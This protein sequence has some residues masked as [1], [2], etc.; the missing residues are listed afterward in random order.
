M[1]KYQMVFLIL[2]LFFVL[3]GSCPVFAEGPDVESYSF[4]STSEK[5][6]GEE[7]LN[8]YEKGST[9]IKAE[10]VFNDMGGLN[11]VSMEAVTNLESYG[12]DEEGN[13]LP[14][15]LEYLSSSTESGKTKVIFQ[16]G[17]ELNDDCIPWVV[18]T[19]LAITAIA[20]GGEQYP[21]AAAP[22]YPVLVDFEAP[23]IIGLAIFNE[24]GS[25]YNY[26][27]EIQVQVMV[28]EAVYI[29]DFPFDNYTFS[30]CDNF[31]AP[32]HPSKVTG[33]GTDTLTISYRL[34][35]ETEAGGAVYLTV[36]DPP[37][38]YDACGNEIYFSTVGSESIWDG[39]NHYYRSF[40]GEIY[41]NSK[42]PYFGSINYDNDFPY[43]RN[44]FM[45]QQET[46][47]EVMD[48][49]FDPAPAVGYYWSTDSSYDTYDEAKEK[50]PASEQMSYSIYTRPDPYNRP[51]FLKIYFFLGN[52]LDNEEGIFYLHLRVIDNCGNVSYLTDEETI[53]NELPYPGIEPIKLDL[54]KPVITC[55]PP[56]LVTEDMEISVQ[57]TD[58]GAGL[59]DE[60]QKVQLFLVGGSEPLGEISLAPGKG[61]KEFAGTIRLSDFQLANLAD[62]EYYFKILARDCSSI[63]VMSEEII[64]DT[65]GN[66]ASLDTAVFRVDS[67]PPEAP[68]VEYR[69]DADLG[70]S[71]VL[72]FGEP[73]YLAYAYS[74][75]EN[76]ETGYSGWRE[77]GDGN[78]LLKVE[79]GYPAQIPVE[80]GLNPGYN[81]LFLKFR[82]A[83]GNETIYRTAEQILI[84]D[85][86][87]G[88]A[89]F[90]KSFI[91]TIN[92]G[93]ALTME[94]D[95]RISQA[96]ETL[97][98]YYR[99]K[100]GG[101]D[102]SEWAP[103]SS[104]C[105]VVL[106]G[107]E[108]KQT[109]TVQ[110]KLV[111]KAKTY[112]SDTVTADITYDITGP[113]GTVSYSTTEETYQPVTATVINISDN[114]SDGT[115]IICTPESHTFIADTA[116]PYEFTLQD[117]AG[118]TTTLTAEVSWI[119]N[120][121]PEGK[122]VYSTKS[123]TN[124][125]V[126]ATL[127]FED[128]VDLSKITVTSND[129]S[130]SHIFT[131]NGSW[132]F[133]YQYEYEE[134][135]FKTG[136]AEANI[137]NIDRTGPV[138]TSVLLPQ[139][140][141]GKK[142]NTDVVVHLTSD[143]DALL[144]V[145]DE[146]GNLLTSGDVKKD[147]EGLS[148]SF[149]QN[150]TILVTAADI[151]GNL[152]ESK[153]IT[154]DCID[155]TPPVVSL[156]YRLE[157]GTTAYADTAKT[158]ENVVVTLSAEEQIYILNNSSMASRVF[159]ENGSYTFRVSDTAGNVTEITATVDK[160]DKTKPVL[161]LQYSTES[162]TNQDVT[163]T[164]TADREVIIVNNNGS[165][166]LTFTVNG[167]KLLSLKDKLGNEVNK[168]VTVSN[169]DKEAPEMVT[170]SS[171]YLYLT[172]GQALGSKLTDGVS[173]IDN[174]DG[175][176]TA[177]IQ[178]NIDI[179]TEGEYTVS[180]Y[181]QDRL[182]NAAVYHR[183]VK[184]VGIS[185]ITAVINE[186]GYQGSYLL[187]KGD[188]AKLDFY[189]TEGTYGVWYD[190]GKYKSAHFKKKP[191]E[192]INGTLT[193]DSAG[194]YTVYV[195]DQERKTKLLYIYFDR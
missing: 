87:E 10:V 122:V 139:P 53:I 89:A 124:G 154:V 153:T 165:N 167:T 80:A 16:A 34:D 60:N 99:Y 81:Y 24:D 163:V 195:L 182:G 109:A 118:N 181:V 128:W 61:V 88:T 146:A 149:T 75:A 172:K 92:A 148:Y 180:Y 18:H 133:S 171:G 102:W 52:D 58:G 132:L 175:A 97:A 116:T 100:L 135:K 71:F 47:I 46:D 170:E 190:K 55:T 144:T 141:A 2:M 9:I 56:E 14:L 11:P 187:V 160:I 77:Y 78:L 112:E 119:R 8:Y 191:N 84:P 50:M 111:Y 169:I 162:I 86:P 164:V 93:L 7:T 179:S 114:Y 76:L 174:V 4:I 185:E 107:T 105:N 45:R 131:E 35:Q 70:E 166:I 17:V 42:K 3:L 106:A 159:T 66:E 151:L 91:N 108:G 90:E 177:I 73:V 157:S 38:V 20:A 129:F 120:D 68:G 192:I 193:A 183:A 28:S 79:N 25:D 85:K 13:Y 145:K 67:T 142:T 44:V 1:R 59:S 33:S 176:V 115:K 15:R 23:N 94:T 126:T 12:L 63:M 98:R 74:T 82:D 121:A 41:V 37:A 150:G 158:K 130:L 125:N 173:F 36:K 156:N 134:G 26:G 104:S 31:L 40:C 138:I 168:L 103:F 57:L 188:T 161:T 95:S 27:D 127:T 39:L 147:G 184:V 54:K 189:G 43:L 123:P 194:W 65:Q 30:F 21:V 117:E 19:E 186:N 5:V 72:N 96:P 137:Y 140:D 178:H 29:E 143:E 32:A 152:S 49:S 6:W 64:D 110:Y 48:D 101:G 113:S 62:G 136:N 51:D 83:S 22:D 69:E 155:K